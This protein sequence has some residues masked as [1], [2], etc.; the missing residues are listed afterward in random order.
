MHQ[1]IVEEASP[2][3]KLNKSV[4]GEG[5]SGLRIMPV[6]TS[7]SG[8]GCF[9]LEAAACQGDHVCREEVQKREQ[10]DSLEM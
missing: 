4:G 2:T 10:E 3:V 5:P 1:N 9:S 7:P 6:D 8:K